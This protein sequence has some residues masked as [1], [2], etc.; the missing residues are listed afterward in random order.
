MMGVHFYALHYLRKSIFFLPNDSRL[1]IAMAKCYQSEQIHLLEDAI[2]CYKIAVN[3]GDTEGIALNL[4]AKLH[5]KLGRN[6]EA[7]FYFEKDLERMDAEG[8]RRTK[9][10]NKNF[11]EAE[12]YCIRLLDDNGPEKEKAKSLLRGIIM[13]QTAFPSMDMEHFPL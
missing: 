8:F 6:E 5:Q 11:D 3:C 2:K 9:H 12:V 13:A 7:V 4:L 10:T 1:W